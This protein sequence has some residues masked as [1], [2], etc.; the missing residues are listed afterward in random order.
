MAQAARGTGN[1]LPSRSRYLSLIGILVAY[2][3]VGILY[4]SETPAWQAPDEP[5]HYNYVRQL[6]GGELP[7]IEPSDYDERYRSEAV[8]SGFAPEYP[9]EP[10]SYEDWQPPLYYLLL[11]PVYLLFDGALLPLRLTSL[12][13]GAGIV[14]ATFALTRLLW[15]AKGWAVLI[16]TIF[17][18]LLPQ[19]VAILSSINNDSLSALI[20]A[21]ILWS[22]A[23]IINRRQSGLSIESRQ[24]LATGIL[25]GLGFITKLTVYIVAPV[26]LI[27]AL[28]IYWKQWSTFLRA[29]L[30]V[31]IPSGLIGGLWWLRNL[32]IYGGF[33]PLAMAAHDAVVVEQPRTS[34]W[35]A[36]YGGMETLQRFVETTFRSFWGQFGWMGVLMDPRIYQV[37]LIFTALIVVGFLWHLFRRSKQVAPESQSQG[38][39]ILASL[40]AI[41]FLL[42]VA[43]YL[44]YNITFVQHQGRYMFVALIPIATAV[45]AGIDGWIGRLVERWSPLSALVPLLFA[46]ALF[47][48]NLVALFKF[49]VP[50]LTTP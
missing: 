22:L 23:R 14:I 2:L 5:A 32:L 12:L 11:T 50:Q 6:A 43:L 9:I 19:H 47:T 44:G 26:V 31:A 17:V 48:L 38:R 39:H 29:I 21:L 16:A 35:I 28:H 27:A 30:T 36:T 20:V 18:A 1:R 4:A 41:T 49:I 33:D 25:L 46:G 7:V 3:F 37:L 42:N 15:P 40:L 24:W 34:E 13:L 45:A 8:S 10:I